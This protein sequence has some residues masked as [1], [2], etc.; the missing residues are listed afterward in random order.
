VLVVL[1]GMHFFNMHNFD[2][3][4]RKGRSPRVVPPGFPMDDPERTATLP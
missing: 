2:R 4:R 1:G 3:M